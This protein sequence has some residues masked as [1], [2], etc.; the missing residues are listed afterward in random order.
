MMRKLRE[1]TGI[2]LWIVIFAFV[3]LIV[4]EWGADYS[5]PASDSVGDT[6]GMIN[7]RKV[8]HREFQDRL[9]VAASQLAQQNGDDVDE[10]RLVREVWDSIVRFELISQEIDRLGIQVTDK[11]LVHYT[12][13]NPPPDVQA[14]EFFQTDG[15]FDPSKYS[16]FI[17]NPAAISDR[18]GRSI[19]RYIEET[20]RQQV[21]INRLQ[22]LVMET[23]QASPSAVRS[24]YIDENEKVRVEYVFSANALVKDE[25]LSFDEQ[26]ITQYYQGHQDEFAHEGQIKVAYVF[27]PRAPT[28]ADS[29]KIEEEVAELREQ[30]VEGA[31]FAELADAVSDDASSAR[32][33]GDLGSFGRGRM[34][35]PFEDAAFGLDEGEISQPVKTRFGWHIIKVDE[36]LE[37]D[38][39]QKM[40]ARHILI[41]HKPSR[42]TEEDL[43]TRV[44]NFQESA[45]A[46]GL[47]TA[48]A[49]EGLEVATSRFL[50]RG[51]LVPGLG[52]GTAWLVNLFFE[53]EPGAVSRWS[54]NERGYWVAELIDRRAASTAPLEEIRTQVERKVLVQ[55]KN[56]VGAQTL[57][58]IH[59]SVQLGN[60]FAQ[61]ATDAE[62]ELVKPEPFSRNGTVPGVGRR[63]EFVGTAFRLRPGELSNVLST[64]RGS[65]LMQLVEK[66]PIDEEQF[67][68]DRTEA[69]VGLLR[70]RQ[71]DAWQAWSTRMYE[72]A[73]IED[74]RHI[75]Y[76]SF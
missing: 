11:E 47:K 55:K 65:Y 57:A 35:K 16:Q 29:L 68:A 1:N 10:G 56:E 46:G 50:N 67:E 21:L 23:V 13:T 72:E 25:D 48:A 73:N 58:K 59:Q 53:S 52:S 63:N 42:K 30:L 66:I 8:S 28:A 40:R 60:S 19:V 9:R 27:W 76:S 44:E 54:A 37:E 2:V 15:Q 34:V 32:E 22:R 6:V 17:T 43:R 45:E 24:R 71:G 41:K 12:R 26:D 33:G 62:H 14:L 70:Q 7:G 18:T 31:D 20:L 49:Q 61:A 4:V 75:F 38:G 5:G 39:E 3:G 69:A 36:K 74:N 51:S 64:P